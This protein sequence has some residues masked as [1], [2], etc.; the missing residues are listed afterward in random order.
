MSKEKTH[1]I[2]ITA[3]EEQML[4]SIRSLAF[5]KVIVHKQND[6]PVRVEVIES[7]MLEDK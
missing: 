6:K 2:R 5:G 1:T 7:V 4:D 3:R